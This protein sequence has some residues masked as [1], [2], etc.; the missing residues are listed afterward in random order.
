M[1]NQDFLALQKRAGLNNRELSALLACD[2]DTVG[3][4]RK[5]DSKVPFTAIKLIKQYIAFM[6]K[7]Y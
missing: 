7:E 4:Y 2:I 3:M 1:I 5:G 6:N